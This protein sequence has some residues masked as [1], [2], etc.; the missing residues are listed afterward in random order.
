M[1]AKCKKCRGTKK[2]NT[3]GGQ[4]EDCRDC[5]GVG[6]LEIDKIVKPIEPKEEKPVEEKLTELADNALKDDLPEVSAVIASV[7]K[8]LENKDKHDK[9]R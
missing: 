2:V 9:R 7:A 1:L 3:M 6:Y 5:K 4:Q 8:T